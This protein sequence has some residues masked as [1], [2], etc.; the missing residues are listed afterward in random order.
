MLFNSYTSELDC[1]SYSDIQCARQ[2]CKFWDA[3]PHSSA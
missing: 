2:Y 3:V 1:T